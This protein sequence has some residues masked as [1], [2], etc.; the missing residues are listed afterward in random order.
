MVFS[1]IFSNHILTIKK[2]IFFSLFA[3]SL[4]WVGAS[5]ILQRQSNSSENYLT[6]RGD[7]LLYEQMI[8]NNISDLS[9]HFR[10][11]ILVPLLAAMLP[12]SALVSL[13]IITYASFF[14]L[15]IA[16][17]FLMGELHIHFIPSL[18]ALF[19]A[20]F[21]PWQLYMFYNPYLTDAFQVMI[22]TLMVYCIFKNSFFLFFCLSVVGMMTKESTI[23][24]VLLWLF[25]DKRQG[26]FIIVVSIILYS[27]I[28]Y[29]VGKGSISSE[30]FS[31]VNF[32]I[33]Q[34]F[35][36]P[37]ELFKNILNSWGYL[38]MLSFLGLFTMPKDKFFLM[39]RIY[40]T[41]WLSVFILSVVAT[42]VGRMYYLLFP[43]IAIT[44]GYFINY[45]YTNKLFFWIV[46]FLLYSSIQSLF[47]LPNIFMNYSLTSWYNDTR[48]F[49]ILTMT[50]GIF[51]V[52]SFVKM[53]KLRLKSIS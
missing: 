47:L 26:L 9:N 1:N 38:W 44:I 31:T 43:F 17:L 33:M 49:R 48:I 37:L 7:S 52:V 22:I 12:F 39:T 34:R 36:N 18:T 53:N 15:Y 10:Y 28:L 46:L 8:E 3:I 45:L 40:V 6:I 30:I 2:S 23:F 13:K 51:L 32:N 27:L 20:F 50:V 25:V 14:L 5:F 42:D 16:A 19:L 4:L 11:R 24:F 29:F 21:S 41:S 35:L